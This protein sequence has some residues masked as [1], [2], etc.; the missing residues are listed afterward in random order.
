MRK[1]N[2]FLS[3]FALFISSALFAQFEISAELR[4]R[5]ELNHGLMSLPVESSEAAFFVTQRSRLNLSYK[6]EHFTTY[7]SLQDVRFWGENDLATKTGIQANT[8]GFGISEAW[9]DWKFTGNWGLKTGRQVWNYDDGRILSHR[10]WNQYGL[11]YDAFLLHLDKEDFHFHVGSSINNTWVLFNKNNFVP[12]GNSYEEPLGYRIKYFN[13]LW[14][15]F[16]VS[17]SLTLSLGNYYASYLKP[18]TK[19]TLYTLG[20][21]GIY[22]QYTGQSLSAEFNAY[23]QY[24]KNAPG[25]SVSAYMLTLSGTYQ[26]KKFNFGLGLDYLSGNKDSEKYE[27]FDLLYGARHKYNGWM[28]Y[29]LIPANTKHSG[30]VDIYPSIKYKI[31]E[32]HSLFASYHIMSLANDEYELPMGGDYSYL[33]KNLGGELNLNYTFKF[34]KTFNIQ[35]FFSYYFATETSEFM[36]GIS[37]GT[38]TS[39]YWAS[40]MLTF[41]PQLFESELKK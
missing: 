6:N 22:A 25:Q 26:L 2:I 1:K 13:F 28:N 24:G 8:K 14:L 10:N 7:F 3:L 41:K 18:E 35:A 33:N 5:P 19:S 23:Y 32:K 21:S 36:K 15:K 37:K 31:S 16:H 4:T 30:L 12:E 34:N 27:A 38:S 29:Y 17:K 11:A 39:P 20:T 40:V 9:F